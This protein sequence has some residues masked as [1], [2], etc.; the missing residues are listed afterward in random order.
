LYYDKNNGDL[1][2]QKI[3]LSLMLAASCN[4]QAFAA[5]NLY[6][7]NYKAQN[8]GGLVSLQANPD[9]KMYVSNH[10]DKD[11]ISMLEN[12]YDMMG[13]TGFEAG[14]VPAE[15][16]LQHAKAIKADTVLVYTKYGAA[17]TAAS[18]MD[19]YKEA[20]K[21]NGGEIDEKDVVEDD[22]KYKYF[23]SYWAKLPPPLL[24]VHVI[25]LARP[26]EEGEKKQELK[27]LNVLAVIKG[28]PAE[29][30]GIERGDMLLKLND[31][32]LNKAEELAKVV[33]QHQGKTVQITYQR[34][35]V[36]TTTSA[37][38]NQRNN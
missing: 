23:A 29:M 14:D 33:R 5:D 30:A 24:G 26:A 11:N 13:T 18:K 37:A 12:G 6:E 1:G 19:T 38:I 31:V 25:K 4:L 9:T 36:N 32:E 7:K 15:L 28:S 2:M 16:A 22:V 35:D 21:T 17:M 3:I 8:T 20:A 34:E 27:G 10:K